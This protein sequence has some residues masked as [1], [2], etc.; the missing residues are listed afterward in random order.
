MS[1]PRLTAACGG[2]AVADA[3]LSA[4]GSR[5]EGDKLL[6]PIPNPHI[7]TTSFA[8]IGMVRL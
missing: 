1:S 8:N 2:A 4:E 5:E 7:A 6:V 3:S